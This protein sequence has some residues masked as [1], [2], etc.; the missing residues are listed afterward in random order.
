MKWI[1]TNIRSVKNRT[2]VRTCTHTH[3][4]SANVCSDTIIRHNSTRFV[5]YLVRSKIPN[6]SFKRA[7]IIRISKHEQFGV[8]SNNHSYPLTLIS[9]VVNT[10]TYVRIIQNPHS[11]TN[12]TLC[13][14]IH[15]L[16]FIS[17]SPSSHIT[18]HPTIFHTRHKTLKITNLRTRKNILN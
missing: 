7:P 1:V 14:K 5:E 4:C 17:I 8:R 16:P 9:G 3:I 13:V 6:N 11:Y 15:L 12:P 2:R 18:Q 10:K